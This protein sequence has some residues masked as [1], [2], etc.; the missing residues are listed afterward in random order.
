MSGHKRMHAI[1]HGLVQGV[2][3]REYTRRQASALGL[4]GWVRNRADGTVEVLFQGEC[5]KVDALLD[6][7][8]TG[9]PYA[10]VHH[11]DAREE[12]LQGEAGPFVIRSSV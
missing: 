3:F 1:V 6:W 7:L 2:A 11:L 8:A 10:R 4:T 9:S 5:A 12:P